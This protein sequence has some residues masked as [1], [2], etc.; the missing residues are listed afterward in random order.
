MQYTAEE[1]ELMHE[2]LGADTINQRREKARRMSE[3]RHTPA[4]LERPRAAKAQRSP[5]LVVSDLE[6]LDRKKC[7]IFFIGSLLVFGFLP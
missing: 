1:D 7:L 6:F 3:R 2:I 5:C 4:R